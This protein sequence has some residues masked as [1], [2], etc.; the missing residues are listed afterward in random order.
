MLTP[1]SDR[2]CAPT[3]LLCLRLC[4]V[5]EFGQ[6]EWSELALEGYLPAGSRTREIR[7]ALGGDLGTEVRTR[8]RSE[9]EVFLAVVGR[10]VGTRE[11]DIRFL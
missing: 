5:D 6:S 3:K 2:Y 8:Y 4:Q 9:I 1:R 10:V 7:N 11:Q